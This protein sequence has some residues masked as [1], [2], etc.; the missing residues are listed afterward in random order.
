MAEHRVAVAWKRDSGDFVYQ[1]YSRDHTWTFEGGAVV[2]ASAA[3]GFLGNQARVDPEEALV[4]AL[5][6][7]HMLS[8]LAI[9][10]RKR[11]IVDTYIDE[12]VGFL[13]RDR[14]GKLA[15]TRAILTP[16]VVFNGP[17]MPSKKQVD[18][19][20][21]RA[22]AVCFIANSVKTDIVIKPKSA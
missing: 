8:F 20:H 5:S 16:T 13:E 17:N 15:I 2:C 18:T 10:A 11:Y 14:E 21:H 4:A 6:S 12:A 19:M 22:N 3:P 7:C 9:A 1:T